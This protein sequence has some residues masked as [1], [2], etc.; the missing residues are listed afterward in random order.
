[1][2]VQARTAPAELADLLD[3]LFDLIITNAAANPGRNTVALSDTTRIGLR[4]VADRLKLTDPGVNL[5]DELS[6]QTGEVVDLPHIGEIL[7]R[8]TLAPWTYWTC[9]AQVQ[10]TAEKGTCVVL[11][12]DEDMSVCGR[13]GTCRCNLFQRSY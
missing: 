12:P 10:D 2:S 7:L 6:R 9:E 13:V 1:M 11:P 8:D 3:A 5:L 4:R